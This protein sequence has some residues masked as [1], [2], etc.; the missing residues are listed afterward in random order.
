[1]SKPMTTDLARED[2]VPLARRHRQGWVLRAGIALLLALFAA[3]LVRLILANS[4]AI[5]YP[6]DLDYGEGI[7]WQQM[8]NIVAGQGYAP[9]G[10][11]PA[12]VYHYPP[13]Y[14]LVVHL[15]AALCG[16]DGLATG[17][18][19]SL[20]STLLSIL[21]VGRLAY[22]AIPSTEPR[23]L[24]I[25]A[26]AIAGG[27]VATSHTVFAWAGYMRVDMLAG[28]L[29]LAGLALVAGAVH[30]PGRIALAALCF[31]AAIYTK[32]TSI[33]APAAAFIALW[34]ARP[35]AAWMLFAW[36]AGL[37]LSALAGLSLTSHGEF[38]RHTILY[39]INRIDVSRASLLLLVA[40]MQA[41][42]L[43]VACVGVAGTWRRLRP[44]AI[45]SLRV[46]LTT[47]PTDLGAL[48]ALAFL[49]LK[50]AMLPTILKSG[51]N[52]NYL[53]E[54]L[55]AVAVFVGIGAVPV[56]RSAWDGRR[57]PSPWLV[58]LVLVGLPIQAWLL[59]ASATDTQWAARRAVAEAIVPRIRQARA[60]VISDDMALLIR[61]GQPVR[62]EPAIVAELGHA[63]IYDEAAFAR[64]IRA[65]RF[66]FF[67]TRGDRG[68]RYYD[69]RYNPVIADAIDAAY[70]RRER[71]GGL[72]LHLPG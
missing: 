60:P 7:V 72:V 53:I 15:V 14:H 24:R 18:A 3:D 48:V 41:P 1:M 44:I 9:L 57:L 20:A 38:L 2:I 21:L 25:I 28:A 54:W 22:A 51:A 65:H 23:A 55:Y 39:N 62:W 37:G 11:Y 67:V 50:T 29:S 32:Q 4:A 13:V 31:V 58:A 19:V 12:I 70:P 43:M 10:I 40:V 63:G 16:S 47:T 33:A 36:C 26:G 17:R 42:G 27:C 66:A 64:L 56:L 6:Y 45:H 71:H 46:R 5:A 35:R 49:I 34:L 69:E 8:L 68:D 61:A 30:R 52:D 59:P